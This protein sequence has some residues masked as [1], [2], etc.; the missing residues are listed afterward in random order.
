MFSIKPVEQ[1]AMFYNSCEN[2]CLT[3]SDYSS[4]T[5]KNK[6]VNSVGFRGPFRVFRIGA[7]LW[8]RRVFVRNGLRG[9]PGWRTDDPR[10]M[11]S[12]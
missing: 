5:F 7:G 9:G 4:D 11:L 1:L 6:L 2:C 3:S 10:K 12:C 8:G